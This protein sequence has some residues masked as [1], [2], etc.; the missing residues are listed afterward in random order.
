V[1]KASGSKTQVPQQGSS[2]GKSSK[3]EDKQ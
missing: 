1:A 2:H 3:S